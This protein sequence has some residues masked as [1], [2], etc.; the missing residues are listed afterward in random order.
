MRASITM[1]SKSSTP[2]FASAECASSHKDWRGHLGSPKS[3]RAWEVPLTTRTL[4]AVKA[5]RH[6]RSQLVFCQDDG[7]PWTVTMMP[8]GLP[9]QE[10]RAGLTGR[11]KWHRQRHTFCSHP[12]MRGAT[13]I[14]IKDLA[15]HRSI[16]TSNRNIH[17]APERRRTAMALLEMGRGESVARSS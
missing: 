12:A 6:L 14:E 2:I 13:A 4:D 7:A 15:G 8:M 10:K 17:L 1:N 16:A 5:V 3:G 11:G 9:R